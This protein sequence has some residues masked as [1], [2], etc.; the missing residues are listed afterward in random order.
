MKVI[1]IG[2]SSEC[3]VVINDVKV[4]RVHAQLVQDD[5]GRISVVDLG[6]T[7][8]T[9]VNGKHIA[10]EMRLSPGDEL[11]VGDTVLPWQNYMA[12]IPSQGFQ[13]VMAN[14]Q[15]PTTVLGQ[16]NVSMSVVQSGKLNPKNNLLWII[17]AVVLGLFVAGGVVWLL[18]GKGSESTPSPT[19][20]DTVD[21]TDSIVSKKTDVPSDSVGLSE[22]EQYLLG[23]IQE[24]DKTI[25]ALKQQNTSNNPEDTIKKTGQKQDSKADEKTTSTTTTSQQPAPTVTITDEDLI[26]QFEGL[27][28]DANQTQTGKIYAEIVGDTQGSKLSQAGQKYE[29]KKKFKGYSLEQKKNMLAFVKSIIKK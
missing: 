12:T 8:G 18:L 24:R 19:I 15:S 29:I 13:P 17:L 27:V 3:S 14:A 25:G 6:S 23:I 10:G 4:S 28:K 16:D 2:R 26:K 11:R 21:S 5:E 7:N 9:K 1:T 20:I 22:Y